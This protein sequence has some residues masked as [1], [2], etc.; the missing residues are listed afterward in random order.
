MKTN[1]IED[2]EI[3][4]YSYHLILNKDTKNIHWGKRQPLQQIVL[5]KLVIYMQKTKTR[6]VSHHI[7]KNSK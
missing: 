3:K 4:P 1:G 6:S 7:K 5:G 2:P